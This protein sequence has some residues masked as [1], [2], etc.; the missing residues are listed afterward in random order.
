[1]FVEFNTDSERPIKHQK[2]T[3]QGQFLFKAN[4]NTLKDKAMFFFPFFFGGGRGG[5]ALLLFGIS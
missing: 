3:F 4:A 2:N 5:V 1:M